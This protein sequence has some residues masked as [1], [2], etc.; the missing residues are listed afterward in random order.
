MRPWFLLERG[1]ASLPLTIAET[2][3]TV[4]FHSVAIAAALAGAGLW[5][6]VL[7]ALA[8]RAMNLAVLWSATRWRP[9]LRWS[10]RELAPVMK[11]GILFQ[12]S[13]LVGIAGDAVVPTFVTVWSGVPA[14]GFLNWAATLAFLP[15][16]VVSI[17]GR[18]LFPALSSLQA[19]A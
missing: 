12:A 14:V 7:G 17:A 8:A 3:D 18:V 9:T 4:T 1:L 11:F 13:I 5:S 2:A 15:L 6:F 16:Q 19:D 10:W